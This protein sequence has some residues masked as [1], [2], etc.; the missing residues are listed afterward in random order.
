MTNFMIMRMSE[1]GE[2]AIF[3]TVGEGTSYFVCKFVEFR[4]F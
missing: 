2:S 3:L 1:I 4:T